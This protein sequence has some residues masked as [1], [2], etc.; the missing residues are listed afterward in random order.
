VFAE[1]PD[2]CLF[3]Q[4]RSDPES[5]A[6]VWPNETDVDPETFSEEAHGIARGD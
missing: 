5:E 3:A 6:I 1:L 2:P 4:V